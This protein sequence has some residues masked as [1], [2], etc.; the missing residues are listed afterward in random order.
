MATNTCNGCHG[1]ETGTSFLMVFPRV[2][3]EEA[4]LSQFL[5]GVTVFDQFA[6]MP[7]TLNDLARRQAS[8]GSLVC[9]PPDAVASQTIASP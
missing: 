2:V 7:R 8:L 1:P 4:A 3:G 9:P 5:T 6:G